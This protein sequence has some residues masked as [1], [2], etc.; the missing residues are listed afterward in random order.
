MPETQLQCNTGRRQQLPVITINISHKSSHAAATPRPG[1]YTA[2]TC[3]ACSAAMKRSTTSCL[4]AML[5]FG[6]MAQL[7]GKAG[8]VWNTTDS[9]PKDDF[10]LRANLQHN[11][12]IT[13]QT[14]SVS[15]RASAL[16]L[17]HNDDMTAQ[18]K[19]APCSRKQ[20]QTSQA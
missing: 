16:S 7:W 18:R 5:G 4:L 11:D 1:C 20:N 10:N 12:S 3:T 17:Q 2:A 15:H 13:Q 6:S 8:S 14:P 9:L 19:M